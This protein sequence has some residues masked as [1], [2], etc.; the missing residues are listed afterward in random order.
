MD[1]L[2][3]SSCLAALGLFAFTRPR[4]RQIGPSLLDSFVIG[5]SLF[6]VGSI[7]V[8]AE[9]LADS[10][11]VMWISVSTALSGILGA[12]LW[13]FVFAPRVAGLNFF[14]DAKRLVADPIDHFVISA[15]FVVAS[16]VSVIL[17]IAVFSH[18]HVRSLLLG[19]LL[20]SSGTLNEA[21]IIVSSGV[22]GYFAPGYVKQ[23]R[24]IIV[25]IL[26]VAA[27]LCD[28]TYRRRGLLF[29]ALLIA[30]AATFISGQRLVIIQYILC[31]G[32]AF[33][34]DRFSLRPRFASIATI[35]LLMLILFGALGAMTKLLGRLDVALSPLSQ[36]QRQQ[37][38]QKLIGEM[39][40]QRDE[41][42][43]LVKIAQDRVN[44]ARSQAEL[45]SAKKN[46]E[47]TLAAAAKLEQRYSQVEQG[48]DLPSDFYNRMADLPVIVAAPVALVHRAVIAVPRENTL[49]YPF[50]I[51][52]PHAP[53]S[54]WLTDLGGIRPGTQSQLSNEL[55][56]VN[57]GGSMGN[58][59]LGLATDIFYNWGWLGVMVVP[60]LY[61]LA[62]LW[63]DIALTASRSALTSAAK[64]FMFFSIPTMYSPFMFV[65]YGGFVAVGILCYAWLRRNGALSFLGIRPQTQQLSL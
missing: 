62:F 48:R 56:D 47:V 31:L 60:V 23:F 18:E 41:A 43:R 12:S 13:G 32:T 20:H 45:Q 14:A 55:S 51:T 25:P 53:G 40:Y 11:T 30:L 16:L 17:L 2:L 10:E 58:S 39:K 21:R 33:L 28:G 27:I 3:I 8:W 59:P 42:S 22:E 37:L 19:A 29:A 44:V 38:A 50:W 49:S 26:C 4:W 63:L 52:Q 35:V 24:D 61:A 5:L 34:I 6:A 1:Y 36:Q 46:L 65:L 7:L 57:K 54:G 15:G 64:I 9:G